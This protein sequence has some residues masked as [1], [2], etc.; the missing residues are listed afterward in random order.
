MGGA[1]SALRHAAVALLAAIIV[2]TPAPWAPAQAAASAFDVLGPLTGLEQHWRIFAP[3]VRAGAAWLEVTERH[4]D[5]GAQTWRL[6]DR[7]MLMAGYRG[8]RWRKLGERVRDP[9]TPCW[10]AETLAGD[11]LF[12][13][14]DLESVELAALTV[15]PAAGGAGVT[16]SPILT[17]RSV[18]DGVPVHTHH[19][20]CAR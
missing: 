6:E 9:N 12:D 20:G 10:L 14:P 16:R 13:G 17:S 3:D 15:H 1:R 8:A 2:V 18:P 4:R 7:R 5:G 11:V 19:Q